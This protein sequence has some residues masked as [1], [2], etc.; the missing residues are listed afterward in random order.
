MSN[1]VRLPDIGDFKNVPVIEVLVKAGDTI[2]VDDT[3]VVL[4]SDK[5][6]MD[7]PSS[8]A[9]TVKEVK[10]KPGDAVTQ[11]DLLLVLEGAG[12]GAAPAKPE[13]A[14]KAAP[15]ASAGGSPLAA[16][17]GQAGYGSPATAG[18]TRASAAPAPKGAAPVSGEAMRAEVLVL[19]AG[20]G[21]YTAAFRA[22]DL[23]KKVVLVERWASLGGV[24][25]NVGCIPSKA[26]LHA[27][28]VIDESQAMA[29]HGISFAAPQIDIDQ[30]R[31]WKEGVVK[32][33]TGG[34]GGLAKQ[35]KVTV[36]TGTARFV[37]PHQIAVE[38]EGKTTVIGFDNAVIAAGS[39]PIKMPFIPHDDPRVIDST[40]ALELDGV[41]KRLLVIGGGIIGLEMATVYHAL[42]SKVTIVELMDQI[43]PGADKDIV[44]PLFKRISKQY[45]AIYLKAKV[46]AVEALPEGLKVTFEGGSAP[47]TDTFD[48]ILVSVGRRP[49]GKLIGAE[50][51]GVAVDERGFI[52]VDKQ[53]RT[54]APHIFAIGDVVGQPMLAHK[55]VHEGKVA[56]EAA[57]GKNSF[58][59]AKVIPSVAYTDPEVAWVGLSETEAKAK[60]IKVGK[61]VFPWAASG[62]SLSLGRD[63]GL[64]KVLFDEE[65]NRIVGCGIVGPSAGDLIAE[66]ALAIE[67]GAD[68][69]D[70]GMTIHPH[71]TLSETVGMAAEA[72]EGTITDLYM[73][74]KKAH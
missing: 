65:S 7:V 54:T 52:P 69:E 9:G 2:A 22:A 61:G 18:G 28:K 21:G 5:A 51:A 35:R 32:R 59:D 45:E 14:E 33:L 41:P 44:T 70:I 31:S 39:E 48:K 60:G 17:A 20:P 42:G 3:I 15:A 50:A 23:G 30:L 4:E 38:H 72:F 10:I 40:G 6:T 73:P 36:V 1:E 49:N 55:A 47:A 66:A 67:M 19:G 43:I 24:C 12:A 11:G 68:A 62:R 63:E 26:L 57:A 56:A 27:A 16:G 64:T 8:V 25:L 74:K 34:L 53:M 13:V 71:P 37:S 58:F 29:S 46:T